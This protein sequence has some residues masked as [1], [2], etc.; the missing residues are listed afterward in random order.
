[1]RPDAC[2][3]HCLDA[4]E[5]EREVVGE[6]E[7][8]QLRRRPGS[9]I[10]PARMARCD[11]GH[12]RLGGKASGRH[13]GWGGL[14]VTPCNTWDV[15]SLGSRASADGPQVSEVGGANTT[16]VLQVGTNDRASA[17][18]WGFDARRNDAGRHDLGW[19]N[20]RHTKPSVRAREDGDAA[21]PSAPCPLGG[22]EEQGVPLVPQCPGRRLGDALRWE[23]MFL[24]QNQVRLRAPQEPLGPFPRCGVAGVD[25]H[26]ELVANLGAWIVGNSVNVHERVAEPRPMRPPEARASVHFPIAIAVA[27]SPRWRRPGVGRLAVPHGACEADPSDAEA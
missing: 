3:F 20:R 2:S 16:A 18:A 14:P 12:P 13:R 23:V 24:Q 11:D 22:G 4:V 6:E 10:R 5:G 17:E 19:P 26:G 1:M 15:F 25:D 21:S 7:V 9:P 8:V 27:A